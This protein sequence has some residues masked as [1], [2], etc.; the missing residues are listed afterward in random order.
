MCKFIGKSNERIL[1]KLSKSEIL[2]LYSIVHVAMKAKKTSLFTCQSKSF[3]SIFFS[4]KVSACELQPF[5]CHDLT[6]AIYSQTAKTLF[7]Q[8]RA[9][10]KT[11]NCKIN[12]SCRQWRATFENSYLVPRGVVVN[13]T[14]GMNHLILES[15]CDFF[16]FIP[17][18]RCW[19][20]ILIIRNWL[21]ETLSA[22]THERWQGSKHSAAYEYLCRCYEIWHLSF[23]CHVTDI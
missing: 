14:R 8:L 3:I 22:V 17:L 5:S 21:I 11:F 9:S 16:Y 20:W 6:N 1:C 12:R 13:K 4:C 15:W 10:S 7:S 19:V 2:R 18:S 23:L